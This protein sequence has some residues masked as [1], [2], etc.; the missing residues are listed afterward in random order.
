M[1]SITLLA[2]IAALL[3][4]TSAAHIRY[5][6]MATFLYRWPNSQH[7]GPPRKCRPIKRPMKRSPASRASRSTS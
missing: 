1:K 7:V 6:T 5:F 4:A 2:G 3:M